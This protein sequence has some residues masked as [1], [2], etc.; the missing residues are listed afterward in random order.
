MTAPDLRALPVV[1]A[2]GHVVGKSV[3]WRALLERLKREQVLRKG[4]R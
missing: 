4:R 1:K 3:D 2:K